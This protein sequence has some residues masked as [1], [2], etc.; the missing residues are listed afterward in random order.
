MKKTYINPRMRIVELDLQSTILAGSDTSSYSL[1]N[2][3]N[4]GGTGDAGTKRIQLWDDD[5]W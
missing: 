3:Q 4:D 2:P 1:S 5:E